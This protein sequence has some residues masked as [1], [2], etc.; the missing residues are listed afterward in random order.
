M[1]SGR[2]LCVPENCFTQAES[3]SKKGKPLMQRSTPCTPSVARQRLRHEEEERT[4]IK[5]P[6]QDAE[7]RSLS[8]DACMKDGDGRFEGEPLWKELYEAAFF[9]L[10]SKLLLTNILD[11]Q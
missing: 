2:S 9:E 3:I 4:E 7:D 5:R 6:E 10:D 1:P 8:R 11:A